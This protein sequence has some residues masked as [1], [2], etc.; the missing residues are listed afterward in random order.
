MKDGRPAEGLFVVTVAALL[1]YN[2]GPGGGLAYAFLFSGITAPKHE[3]VALEPLLSSSLAS[4]KLSETYVSNCMR[5][6]AATYEGLLR[7]GRTLAEAS[8]I[9]TDGWEARSRVHDILS[10][11]T[12]D[13]ILGRERL[14][15]PD[16]GEVYEFENGFYDNYDI[17]RENYPVTNLEPLPADDHGLWTAPTLDGNQL[18]Q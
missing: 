7:A 15:N 17:S 8:D 6:Q 10:E 5:Q 13:S 3:F 11:K 14:Y 1:P 4:F 2:G 16:T 9:I 12:S 18:M